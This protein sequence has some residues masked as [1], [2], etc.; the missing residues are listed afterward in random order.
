M[1]LRVAIRE[2]LNAVCPGARVTPIVGDA[3]SRRFYRVTDSKNRTSVLMDYGE[4]FHGR[5]Y[6][7]WA[8]VVFEQAGL[9]VPG[10]VVASA[11]AGCL[12]LD[13]LGT[14]SL[15]S[16]L[17]QA[18]AGT[19]GALVLLERAVD[20]AAQVALAGTPVLASMDRPDGAR[21]DDAR[22]RFEMEFFLEH[23]VQGLA[24]LEMPPAGLR[25]ELANLA[26]VAAATPRGVL[27]HR[28]YHSR[29]ILVRDDS[30]L[31][32]VDIQDA[33]V[34]PD[35]YDL[36]SL[37]FDCYIDIDPAAIAPLIDRFCETAGIDEG[38]CE[39]R[40]RFDRVAAQR[41]LKALGTFG[42]QIHVL[43]RD[44]YRS[45]IP[46]TLARLNVLLPTRE[47]TRPLHGVLRAAGL[48]DPDQLPA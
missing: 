32:M 15:E 17:E 27:C 25:D 18:G 39:F 41:M 38:T 20:L 33:R 28:D 6:D 40:E 5:T 9:P 19:A 26:T 48:L 47:E 29:N 14:T 16:A 13:D 30:S 37:L 10:I 21:L 31:A 45:A 2:F 24:G 23:Y 35:S 42:N 46:R 34:G 7:Q 3:S 8:T 1:K 4:P 11:D 12:I 22:F 43:G 36:A 44:R